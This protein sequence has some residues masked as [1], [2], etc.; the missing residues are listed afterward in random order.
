GKGFS[1]HRQYISFAKRL[2][3][4]ASGKGYRAVVGFNKMPGLDL[5]FAADPC[6]VATVEQRSRVYRLTSRYRTLVAFER[7][8][9]EPAAKTT[10]LSISE[11]QK[12]LFQTIYK[13]PTERFHDL[14]PG[15]STDRLLPSDSLELGRSLREELGVGQD[16]LVVLMIGSGFKRK[17]VDRALNAMQAL[18]EEL[19]QKS[20]LLVVGD[21]NLEYYR[22]LARRQG[23]AERV[24]F[25][26][27]RTDVLRFLAAADL[28]LH[29]AYQENTGGVL[30]EALAAGLPVLVTSVCG[31]SVHIERARAGK[32]VASPFAQQQLDR[33][34]FEML[35]SVS[36]RLLWSA[37]AK[38]YVAKTDLFSL[39]ERAAEIIMKVAG[40]K[41]E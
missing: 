40:N 7:A 22:K 34:L 35:D 21:D 38:E 29:P 23:L 10:I 5:Y 4:Q 17:G 20:R 37:N 33:L 30:I 15:V 28:F 11:V 31:Y 18:P 9:F 1:H 3:D 14:P 16:E 26:G 2:Q 6:Y 27:G 25:T 8:V 13:T 39:A 36:Q 19:C 32:L 41:K 24:I 12:R